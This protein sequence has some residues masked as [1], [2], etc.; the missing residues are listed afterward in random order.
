L[1]AED[2]SANQAWLAANQTRLAADQTWLAAD[3]AWL[4][5]SLQAANQAS[6]AADHAVKHAKFVEE[7]EAKQGSR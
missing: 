5:R 2:K 7:Q 4:E 3:H 1:F 6:F